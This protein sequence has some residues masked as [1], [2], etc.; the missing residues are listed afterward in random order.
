MMMIIFQKS[1]VDKFSSLDG[2]L[3]LSRFLLLHFGRRNPPPAAAAVERF[4]WIIGTDLD[5]PLVPMMVIGSEYHPPC[6]SYLSKENK[7]DREPPVAND[8]TN[9]ESKMATRLKM[10]SD[11]C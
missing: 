6:F 10:P 1:R 11:P 8:A 5:D 7:I 4:L 3:L 2:C 9:A